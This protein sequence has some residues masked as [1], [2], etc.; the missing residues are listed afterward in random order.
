MVYYWQLLM[1]SFRVKLCEFFFLCGIVVL[2]GR[3][4]CGSAKKCEMV[5]SLCFYGYFCA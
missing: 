2:K 1:C 5:S 3:A 4:V